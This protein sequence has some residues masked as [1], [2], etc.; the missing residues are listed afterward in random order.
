[1]QSS[2]CLGEAT[3]KPA[4][5]TN[6]IVQGALDGKLGISQKM[7]VKLTAGTHV[8]AE[9]NLGKER[10]RRKST[11]SLERR[12]EGKKKWAENLFLKVITFS[13]ES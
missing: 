2:H 10:E 6:K 8:K 11:D 13:Q 1:M 4:G 9:G 5:M 3:K 7:G 12:A